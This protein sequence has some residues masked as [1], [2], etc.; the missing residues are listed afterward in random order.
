MPP[1]EIMVDIP[2]TIANSAGAVAALAASY[3]A[4]KFSRR[5][6][7]EMGWAFKFVVFGVLV[8]TITR[9]DDAIKTVGIYERA[10]LDYKMLWLPHHVLVLTGW[11]FISIGLY[12]MYRTFVS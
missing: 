7:G 12:K 10:G 1:Q 8:F 2:S 5:V 6:G 3:F 11:A 4:W 9:V